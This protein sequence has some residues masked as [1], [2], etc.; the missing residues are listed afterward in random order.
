MMQQHHNMHLP[1]VRAH[2]CHC[3]VWLIAVAVERSF[4][5]RGV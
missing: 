1:S 2:S 4:L 5:L 3:A